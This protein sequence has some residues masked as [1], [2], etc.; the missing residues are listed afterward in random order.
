LKSVCD[1]PVDLAGGS[2]W[3]GRKLPGELTEA[4][5]TTEV[6]RSRKRP[7]G[8]DIIPD[9][10]WP[11]MWRVRS[12]DGTLSDM[13]SLARARD[14]ALAVANTVTRRGGRHQDEQTRRDDKRNPYATAY[15]L[16][17]EGPVGL[18]PDVFL[19]Q[20]SLPGLTGPGP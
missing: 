16:P 20:Q 19:P 18:P 2:K 5:L 6:G 8:A 1:L 14:L 13:L 12:A 3:P 10:H 11:N 15:F 4:I 7:V 9:E 17:S